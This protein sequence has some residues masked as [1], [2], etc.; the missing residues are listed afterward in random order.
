MNKYAC[1]FIGTFTL[2][3]AGTGAI[4]INDVSGG[5]VTHVGIAL[6]FGFSVLAMIYAVGDI[7]GAHI[8]PAVTA[9]FLVAGRISYKRAVLYLFSQFLGGICASICLWFLL[10]HHETMGAS[11]PTIAPAKALVFETIL[12]F[13]LMFVIARVASGAKEKGLMAGVAVG[14]TIALESM[15]A[16]PVTGASMNPAR[17]LGPALVSGHFE[18]LWI[19]MIGP[20]IGAACAVY[21]CKLMGLECCPS[22]PESTPASAN[23]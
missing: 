3:F 4:I 12:T 6:T 20:F 14:F 21:A 8:N 10:P 13:I 7:S 17:S 2:V 22:Q 9:G 16:G 11:L 1:E 15:F 5:T 18:H 19:Y 23:Q